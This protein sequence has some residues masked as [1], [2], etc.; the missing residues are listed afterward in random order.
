MFGFSGIKH[1]V[2][3]VA[4]GLP[5]RTVKDEMIALEAQED[6]L[7]ALLANRPAGQPPGCG[8]L[9]ASESG[10]DLQGQVRGVA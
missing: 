2:L 8:T 4:E 9:P 10:D 7:T 1:L 5:H 6:E 3:A